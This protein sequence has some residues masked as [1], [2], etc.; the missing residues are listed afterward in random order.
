MKTFHS[1]KTGKFVSKEFA[2]ANP[3]TTVEL[4]NVNLRK[5]LC[6]FFLFFRMFG[7]AYTGITIEQ[8]V[9]EYLNQK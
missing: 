4:T 3:D 5:E 6:D 8:F 7:E 9:D 2:E 1:A